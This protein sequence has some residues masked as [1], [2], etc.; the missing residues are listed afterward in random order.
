M[1]VPVEVLCRCF[2]LGTSINELEFW[3]WPSSIM[4]MGLEGPT[5]SPTSTV[6]F[7]YALAV[8]KNVVLYAAAGVLAWPIVCVVRRQRDSHHGHPKSL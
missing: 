4:F 2:L 3:F 1:V 7:V 6:V 5:I 8:I